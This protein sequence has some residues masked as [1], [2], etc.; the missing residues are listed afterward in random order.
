MASFNDCLT[1]EGKKIFALM[2]KG[3]KVT[4]TKVVV[5]DGIMGGNEKPENMTA[6]INPRAVLPVD[7]VVKTADNNVIIRAV[8]NNVKSAI[9][10]FY[11]R[12]KGIYATI[13]GEEE[14]L[15][16]YAN[17]G[18]LAE[19]IDSARTQLIEKIIRTI[20]TFSDSDNI[21]ITLSDSAYA[22]PTIITG[23]PTIDDFKEEGNS[24]EIGSDIIITNKDGEKEIWTYIGGDTYVQVYGTKA[25]VI[26]HEYIPPSERVRG[27]LYLQLGK[28]RRLIIK[29]FHK[30]FRNLATIS[31]QTV[32]RNGVTFLFNGDGS[33]TVTGTAADHTSMIA[34]KVF[35][36]AN[37]TYVLKGGISKDCKVDLRCDSAR[38]VMYLDADGKGCASTGGD[39]VFTNGNSDATVYVV[40]R[41]EGGKTFDYQRVYPRVSVVDGN[42]AGDLYTMYFKETTD[43]TSNVADGNNYRFVCKNM[44]IMQE[45]DEEPERLEGKFYFKADTK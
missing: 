40:V 13:D 32:V 1:K 2:A 29:V 10:A 24:V 12:E 34:G 23:A 17:N 38:S 14:Y 9:S 19:Y 11:L 20:I 27:S 36:K 43:K 30:F 37:E 15:V 42:A 16:F 39:R 18:A 5:G 3:C 28:T 35:L 45:G 22:P 25:L 4:F 26:M 31:G 33:I 6:V 7:S 44:T 8:F 21:N 41:V